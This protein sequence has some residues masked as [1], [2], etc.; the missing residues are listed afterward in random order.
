VLPI[1]GKVDVGLS[2]DALFGVL[3]QFTQVTVAPPPIV[4]PASPCSNTRSN[5]GLASGKSGDDETNSLEPPAPPPVTVIAEEVV[6]PYETVQLAST[7]PGA[8]DAWLKDH[9]YAIPDDVVPVVNAYVKEGFDFLALKLVPG[10]G[11]KS[12]RPVRVT[13]P[14]AS[15]VLPL[16][17]VAAGTGAITP[18]TLWILGESAYE[19]VSA[20]SFELDASGLIW[21]WDINES[22]Y[23]ALKQTQLAQHGGNAWLLQASE[24][25]SSPAIAAN[26]GN[27]VQN[28]PTHSGYTGVP[29]K[30]EGQVL[31]EDLD[32]LTGSIP[33]TSL[34]VTRLHAELSRPAL[35]A[36]LALQATQHG[37][38]QRQFRAQIGFG[39][40]P[41]CPVSTCEAVDTPPWGG[42]PKLP[43]TDATCTASPASQGSEGSAAA[44]GLALTAALAFARRR[45]AGVR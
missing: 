16:R 13:S 43:Y 10:Q 42:A 8:L 1:K 21:R 36:D 37:F 9:G 24:P 30:S 18:I 15:P 22:N 11:V 20:P 34:A 3:D 45:R 38:V 14:G 35:A 5:V 31:A 27:L 25:I 7:D 44:A 12:M 28:D 2:S 23:T 6:G 26:L 40:P 32:A 33:P 39:T 19:P 4:C 17:M 29:G 41:P